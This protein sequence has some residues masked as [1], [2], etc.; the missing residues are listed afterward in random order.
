MALH[1]PIKDI[2]VLGTRKEQI[3]FGE[4]P[5][6]YRIGKDPTNPLKPD[7]STGQVPASASGP[8]FESRLLAGR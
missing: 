3:G 2:D 5:Q 4:G 8:F 1:E 6:V 7:T